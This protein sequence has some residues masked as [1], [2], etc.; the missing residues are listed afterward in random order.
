MNCDVK[1]Y[2]EKFYSGKNNI[3]NSENDW[4]TKLIKKDININKERSVIVDF[5]VGSGDWLDLYSTLSD[6]IYAIDIDINCVEYCKNKFDLKCINFMLFD[7][8]NIKLNDSSVDVIMVFWVFQEIL[9]DK[10]LKNIVSEFKRILK[11]QG[12]III[13][14]NIYSDIRH[15]LK[16]TQYG[17]LLEKNTNDIIRQFK[18]NSVCSIFEEKHLNLLKH[19]EYQTSFYEIYIKHND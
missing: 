11:P 9:E 13:V 18:N 1:K 4:I 12:I 10:T 15:L 5:G 17:D 7:G 6:T 14:D 3:Y 16:S 8:N 19:E 2:A